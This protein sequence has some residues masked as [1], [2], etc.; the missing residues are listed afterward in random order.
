[1]LQSCTAVLHGHRVSYLRAGEGSVV[2]LLHGIGSN[3]ATWEPVGSALA[4]AHD[5]IAPD[6]LGHGAS[7]KPRGDYSLG[8]FASGVRDLLQLLGVE[9]ATIVGH[10]LGGGVA[11]QLAYQ[12]PELCER[13]VLVSSG[14]LGHSVSPLLR[15]AA[16]PGSEWVLP[17]VAGAAG[18]LG[19]KVGGA[20]ARVGLRAGNDMAEVGRG[21][22]DLGD[23]EARLAFLDTLRSVVGPGGQRV[24]ALDRLYL[25][26]DLPLLIVWGDCDPIIPVGHGR[27]AHDAVPGSELLEIEGA[28]HFPQLDDP[29]GF[30]TAVNRFIATREPWSY[31]P[32][33]IREL[34]L[35]GAGAR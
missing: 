22:A 25:A 6:F 32:A 34:M 14:G 12:H 17:L 33:R 26:A 5:V 11:M 7:A 35:A 13:L 1:M 19:A 21:M 15:A 24:S 29:A 27:R 20:L 18:G 3:A 9:R 8:A 30:V 16:L 28:G 2:V 4:E 10:S 23:R 31:D